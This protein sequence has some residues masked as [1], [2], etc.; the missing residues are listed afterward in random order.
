VTQV[1]TGLERFGETEW[2]RFRTARL[3]LLCNHASVDAGLRPAARIVAEALPGRLRALFGPQH[4]YAGAD[5]DNMIETDHGYD[6]E[7]GVPVYSLYADR[8][9]PLPGMLEEI[10]VL[11]VD[12]Q[13]V[14]TRVYTFSSTLLN[15]MQAAARSGRRVVVLDRPN[16]LGGSAV[17]GN[18]LA[19]DMHSF[20][21]PAR[22]PMRHGLT[23]GEMALFFKDA[24]A[25]DVD[26]EVVRMGGWRRE[27]LWRDTGLRWVLPSPNM[28]LAETALVY[29]GQVIWEGTNVS[30]GRGTCRPFEIFGAPFLHPR[31]LLDR[32][33]P[34]ALEGALLQPFAFKP[35]FHKWAGQE[36]RG[37][38]LHVLDPGR[39]QPYLASLS[40]LSAVLTDGEGA[41]AWREP[42]YEYEAERLPIDL[43]LGDSGLRKAV[44][45]GADPL[46]LRAGWQEDL[47][48]FKEARRAFLLYPT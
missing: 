44:E 26:L 24:L 45:G 48:G 43:I 38:H 36:C 32:V 18:L 25:I 30:E 31:R 13:D 11:A 20:V 17:E 33:S 21:G 3:G 22:M 12:L 35:T 39:F 23:L 15:C 7:L 4:G 27:M 42:P 9:E 1:A 5:Q 46:E 8:R 6:A 47:S 37:F 28:P 29:P 40:L 10:D 2:K 14:G 16:P 34:R 19:P 41:F